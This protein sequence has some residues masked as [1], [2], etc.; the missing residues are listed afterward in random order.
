VA[1]IREAVQADKLS[2]AQPLRSRWKV[3]HS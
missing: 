3:L 1:E 2:S